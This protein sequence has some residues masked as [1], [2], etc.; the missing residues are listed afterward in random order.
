MRAGSS[1]LDAA[2]GT[3]ARLTNGVISRAFSLRVDQIA[4]QQHRGADADR[5]PCTAAISGFVAFA[6]IADSSGWT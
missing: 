1:Q 5:V 4:M 3:R 6:Q 2:S